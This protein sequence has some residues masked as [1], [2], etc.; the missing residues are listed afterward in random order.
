MRL[1]SPG[2]SA[3]DRPKREFGTT[4]ALPC[5]SAAQ[6][7]DAMSCFRSCDF[8]LR[9]SN[10]SR[11][12]CTSRKDEPC[13]VRTTS[14][15]HQDRHERRTRVPEDKPRSSIGPRPPPSSE[16]P[17]QST[18]DSPRNWGG[19]WRKV[20]LRLGS[21]SC[22]CVWRRKSAT[23]SSKRRVDLWSIHSNMQDIGLTRLKKSLGALR[24][25]VFVL[26]YETALSACVAGYEAAGQPD[27]AL[28]YLHEL[29]GAES[30]CE[31]GPGADAPQGLR[32]A[33]SSNQPTPPAPSTSPWPITAASCVSSSVNVS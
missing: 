20:T 6:Y 13:R 22:E 3:T 19:G 32:E 27:V 17:S 33:G 25:R 29:L 23:D 12:D 11:I 21:T 9:G 14:G 10:R 30:R 16:S 31:S 4:S 2:N 8:G 15:R 7:P 18:R 28:I 5:M 1:R 26:R 24:E